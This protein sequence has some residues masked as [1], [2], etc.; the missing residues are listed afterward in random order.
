MP[1]LFQQI[2]VGS[3]TED[4]MR[5]NTG[6]TWEEWFK[7]LDKAGARMMDPDEI[8]VLLQKQTGLSH[9]WS[10]RVALAYAR[11][12]PLAKRYEVTLTKIVAV[13]RATIWEAW[14]DSATL[15]QWLPDARFE[16]SKEVPP[17][18]LQLDWPDETRVTVRLFE[19]R[20]KT[21]MVVS[22]GKLAETDAPRQQQY[23]S[24]A[25]DRLI[26]ILPK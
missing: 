17:K 24:A 25:L 18:L 16:V 11:G 5:A 26:A 20:G 15:A 21:R 4:A 3:V 22:H 9:W 19:R 6:K 10:Q 1:K 2:R 14:H 7:I 13:P 23:W 12:E 8:A